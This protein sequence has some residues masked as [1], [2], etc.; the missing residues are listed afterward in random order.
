M[1]EKLRQSIAALKIAHNAP[2]EDSYLTVS[3]GLAT[4]TP[5]QSTNCRLLISAADKGLYL[6]KHNGRNQVGIE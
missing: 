2:V 3:I 1:A 6:A 5:V 4:I